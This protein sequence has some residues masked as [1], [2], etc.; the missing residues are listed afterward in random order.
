MNEIFVTLTN[1][2]NKFL[3][4]P[5]NGKLE[6]FEIGINGRITL[7]VWRGV[8][9]DGSLVGGP[10]EVRNCE[11]IYPALSASQC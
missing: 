11:F 8:K 4:Y 5:C 10:V 1:S 6:L 2:S 3:T 7:G 9:D